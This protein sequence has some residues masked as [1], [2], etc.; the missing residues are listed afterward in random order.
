MVSKVV[1][2]AGKLAP[3]LVLKAVD[4]TAFASELLGR[5]ALRF[6]VDQNHPIQGDRFWVGLDAH[7]DWFIWKDY[8]DMMRVTVSETNGMPRIDVLVCES[9]F[10]QEGGAANTTLTRLTNGVLMLSDIF[11]D[12][13]ST[14][15]DQ[16]LWSV[17]LARALD[18]AWAVGSPLS[19]RL[20]ASLVKGNFHISAVQGVGVV[21]DMR[22]DESSIVAAYSNASANVFTL[23]QVELVELLGDVGP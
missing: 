15:L 11:Q 1:A 17:S 8:P 3:D 23:G 9:R 6:Y 19:D 2:H 4:R 21:W 16:E 18:D 14:R 22:H 20:R 7:Q 5:H 10:S 12:A 13:N